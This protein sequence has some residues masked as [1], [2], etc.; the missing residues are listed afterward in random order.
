MEHI[1][2]SDPVMAIV[3]TL[4]KQT[5]LNYLVKCMVLQRDLVTYGRVELFLITY[6]KLWRVS[7]VT[8]F[9]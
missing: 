5:F 1:L 3:G 8:M 7:I 9:L 4:T 6:E 2:F